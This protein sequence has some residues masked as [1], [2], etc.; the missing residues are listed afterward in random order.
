MLLTRAPLCI[1][2]SFDLHVL[3]TPP[4]FVLSQN[5]TLQF[6]FCLKNKASNFAFAIYSNHCFWCTNLISVRLNSLAIQISKSASNFELFSSSFLKLSFFREAEVYFLPFRPS[7]PFFNFFED[8]FAPKNI[9]SGCLRSGIPFCRKLRQ[10]RVSRVFGGGNRDRTCDLLN[11]NQ[12]LSQL[13]YAPK[14]RER[15]FVLR[16][17]KGQQKIKRCPNVVQTL[18]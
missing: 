13:S 4:A 5:Q 16:E 12:T 1:A 7:T 3:G 2:T 9:K 15:P 10:K 11:A 17:K 18:G 14:R 8:F 6:K